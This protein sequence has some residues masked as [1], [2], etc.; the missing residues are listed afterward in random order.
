MTTPDEYEQALRR[1]KTPRDPM[2]HRIIEKRRRDRMNNCLA[3]LSRLIP[4]SYLKQGQG[5]IE[6]TEIIEMAIKHIK[7][8]QSQVDSKADCKSS[9]RPGAATSD[10]R[11]GKISE[12]SCCKK[13]FFLGFQECQDKVMQFL[14][15]GEA[16]SSSDPLC[17]RMISHLN[18]AGKQLEVLSDKEDHTVE[19]EGQLNAS[20]YYSSA[21]HSAMTIDPLLPLPANPA[22]A[23]IIAHANSVR[24]KHLRNLLS[25]RGLQQT[26]ADKEFTPQAQNATPGSSLCCDEMKILETALSPVPG[27]TRPSSGIDEIFSGGVVSSENS[28]IG[29]VSSGYV[30]DVSCLEKHQ[31]VLDHSGVAAHISCKE[32]AINIYKFK[33]SITKR[34]SQEGKVIPQHT[35]DGSSSTSSRECEEEHS[36]NKSLK[37]RYARGKSRHTSSSDSGPYPSSDHSYGHERSKC[38]NGD[39]RTCVAESSG[40]SDLDEKNDRCKTRFCKESNSSVTC[41][42]I[43]RKLGHCSRSALPLPGFVLHPSGTHYMPMS[44]CYKNIPEIFETTETLQGPPV[45]HPISI[46]VHFR[47]PVIS[48]PVNVCT[49]N[50]S[51]DRV[52]CS[53]ISSYTDV[54]HSE[55][56]DINCTRK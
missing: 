51:E 7:I 16:M 30:S 3:D 11:E 38:L 21:A 55:V 34:F 17:L 49:D 46:P 53:N 24:D 8:L 33:H 50:C 27:L 36:G 48:L 15:E 35:Y 32:N 39:T 12:H 10:E 23:G 44:V 22:T 13:Q 19:A 29:G 45:F 9:K 40:K 14:M 42:L 47:G 52:E 54:E 43:G 4:T 37:H 56:K 25:S 18:T 31:N 1:Q 26:E 2:S 5:R 28:L 20:S 6:K 41:N